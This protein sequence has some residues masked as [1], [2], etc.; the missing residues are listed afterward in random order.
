MLPL[1]WDESL[2][3]KSIPLCVPLVGVQ[4]EPSAESVQLVVTDAVLTARSSVFVVSQLDPLLL[5]EVVSP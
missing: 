1:A 2:W 5:V 4:V 3:P